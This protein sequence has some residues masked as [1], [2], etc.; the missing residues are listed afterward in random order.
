MYIG[1]MYQHLPLAHPTHS[2]LYVF[3]KDINFMCMCLR[4]CVG[5]LMEARRVPRLPRAGAVSDY[6]LHDHV[7]WDLNSQENSMIKFIFKILKVCER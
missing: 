4:T 1:H 2:Q 5:M 7:C 6:E 3:Q